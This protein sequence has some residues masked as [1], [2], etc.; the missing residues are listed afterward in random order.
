MEA[1]R[2]ERPFIS[3]TDAI[4]CLDSGLRQIF[5]VS[6]CGDASCDQTRPQCPRIDEKDAASCC[7]NVSCVSVHERA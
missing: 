7:M 6:Q 4:A 2:S 5:A 1:E 3:P